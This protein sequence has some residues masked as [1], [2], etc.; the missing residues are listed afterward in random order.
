MEYEK[1]YNDL[2]ARINE[3]K[4]KPSLCMK[5]KHHYNGYVETGIRDALDYIV[6][7]ETEDE[8]IRETLANLIVADINELIKSADSRTY[9]SGV[10]EYLEDVRQFAYNKGLVDA[11]EKQKEQKPGDEDRYMEGYKQAEKDTIERAI[12]WLITHADDYIVDM[13]VSRYKPSKLHVG[14]MCWEDLK[15]A[16]EDEQ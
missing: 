2:I 5:D 6:N 4:E 13:E 10:K 7:P 15:K 16:M 11:K 9:F 3:V 1:A 8:S 12:Q 14:G